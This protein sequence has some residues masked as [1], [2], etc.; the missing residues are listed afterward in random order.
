MTAFGLPVAIAAT[1]A[2]AL[3]A[4]FLARRTVGVNLSTVVGCGAAIGLLVSAIFTA[5]TGQWTALPLL[6]AVMRP[7]ASASVAMPAN[8]ASPWGLPPCPARFRSEATGTRS[9]ADADAF[10]TS[11]TG[12]IGGE[13]RR[14]RVRSL[15][16]VRRRG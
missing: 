12:R 13:E 6:R 10:V 8:A 9:E 7:A 3:P 1:A 14:Q 16:A 15:R 5:F 2:L 11:N 4:R